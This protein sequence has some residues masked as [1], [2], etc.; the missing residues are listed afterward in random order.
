MNTY[1]RMLAD[2]NNIT[3]PVVARA[4]HTVI[5]AAAE[6]A[7]LAVEVEQHPAPWESL[8]L[9]AIETVLAHG[10]H[11]VAE[12]FFDDPMLYDIHLGRLDAARQVAAQA[13]D[14]TLATF[15][16]AGYR[17]DTEHQIGRRLFAVYLTR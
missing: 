6:H 4:V 7:T 9:A 3:D 8:Y 1:L 14:V 13:R 12:P 17:I 5:A 11:E 10:D 15:I 2:C 16:E